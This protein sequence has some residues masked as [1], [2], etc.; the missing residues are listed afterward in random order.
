MHRLGITLPEI[1]E[2]TDTLAI[3]VFLYDG[4]TVDQKF[5]DLI[6]AAV[7]EAIDYLI[8]NADFTAKKLCGHELWDLLNDGE[9]RRAGVCLSHMVEIGV[10]PLER[11]PSRRQS[12][13]KYRLKHN[14]SS[15]T[16]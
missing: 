5:Y 16:N 10:L 4:T 7:G 12:S 1:Y 8:P 11:A 9:Q 13:L 6:R 15:I 2:M 14:H 3:Y